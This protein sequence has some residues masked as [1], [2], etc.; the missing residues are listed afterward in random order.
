MMKNIPS[1][2]LEKALALAHHTTGLGALIFTFFFCHNEETRIPAL[3]LVGIWSLAALYNL[4]NNLRWH[5]NTKQL[6]R[7]HVDYNTRVRNLE[8]DLARLEENFFH[9]NSMTP[10]MQTRIDLSI[11][12]V[13]GLASIITDDPYH[14]LNS[15]LMQYNPDD[16]SLNTTYLHGV[17]SV[18]LYD[19][20]F[21]VNRAGYDGTCG[22]AF[23]ENRILI[24]PDTNKDPSAF[25]PFPDERTRLI[26][27]INIPVVYK[28]DNSYYGVCLNIDSPIHGVINEGLRPRAEQ[29]Q[30]ILSRIIELKKRMVMV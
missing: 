24:I 15:N 17:Y 21:F 14:G 12:N 7:R 10:S 30:K 28:L 5:W 29:I 23:R 27:I 4:A 1:T 9:E 25:L 13:L 19:R 6:Q 18:T 11:H 8:S 2:S 20:K 3:V 22:K 26:G 16:D